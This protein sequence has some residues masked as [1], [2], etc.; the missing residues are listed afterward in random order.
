MASYADLVQG[1]VQEPRFTQPA[2][3]RSTGGSSRSGQGRQNVQGSADRVNNV[4]QTVE[5][6]F[7]GQE[8]PPT[9][10]HPTKAQEGE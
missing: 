3:A 10:L 5:A 4:T 7:E 8:Q 6:V 1:S 9:A 2:G